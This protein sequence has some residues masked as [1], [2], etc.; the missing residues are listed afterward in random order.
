MN[1]PWR[2][3]WFW[4]G[5]VFTLSASISVVLTYL[6]QDGTKLLEVIW[7]SWLHVTWLDISKLEYDA[8]AI[9]PF[10]AGFSALALL[11]PLLTE[12]SQKSEN[13]RA[14][15]SGCEFGAEWQRSSLPYIGYPLRLMIR[16]SNTWLR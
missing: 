14:F 9:A 12:Q 15:D 13:E 5:V 10:Y 2:S 11:T 6:Q 1:T 8:D 4:K 3:W 16:P 7:E